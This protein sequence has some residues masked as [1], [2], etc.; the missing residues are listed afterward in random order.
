MIVA[1][2]SPLPGIAAWLAR[3]DPA[4]AR[5]ALLDDVERRRAARLP[6]AAAAR[7]I[8][9][10]STL[11]RILAAHLGTGPTL[12]IGRDR[13]RPILPDQPAVRI[14]LAYSGDWLALALAD[15][16]VG[17]DVERI[18]D[19]SSA[20]AAAAFGTR[21]TLA[22]ASFKARGDGSS[23]DPA[24]HVVAIG[25]ADRWGIVAVPIASPVPGLSLAIA[26]A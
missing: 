6:E 12:R 5:L 2:A 8:A 11:R 19:D 25:Q 21:W 4:A 20:D 22:E 9:A 18:T 10:R 7:Y 16:R 15:R 3:G 13:G 24:D 23:F 14:S 26:A 17:V 1:L